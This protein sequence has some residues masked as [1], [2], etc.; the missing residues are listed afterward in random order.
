MKQISS[1][2][3]MAVHI[4][5]LIALMPG[6]CTGDIIAGSVDTNPVVIRRIMGMLKKAGLIEVRAGVGGATLLKEPSAISLL[7]VYLAVEATDKGRLFHI[8]NHPNPLCP[9][10]RTIEV[11]LHDELA[12]AQAAMESQLAATTIQLMLEQASDNKSSI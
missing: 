9:V 6:E 11:S 8:H 3:S 2:F 5:T 1:R 4:L 10:G 12:K 7:D